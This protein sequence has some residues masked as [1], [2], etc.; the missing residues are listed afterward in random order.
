MGQVDTYL[1]FF[2]HFLAVC[3]DLGTLDMLEFIRRY[4][5][6]AVYPMGFHHC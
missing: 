1:L 4:W 5:I 6:A 2:V 3:D